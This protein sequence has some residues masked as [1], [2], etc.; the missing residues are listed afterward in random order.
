MPWID[1]AWCVLALA[2][3][4]AVLF[5][6]NLALYNKP[7]A[8]STP[9][10]VSVLIPARNEER[11][12][13]TSVRAALASRNTELE[14]LVLDDNSEDATAE[15]VRC[16][17]S[18]DKRLHLFAAPPLPPGWCGKQFACSVL[19]D[20]AS[21][22][23]LCFIDAD[24]QL[25]PTG[26]ADMVGALRLR[27]SALISGFPQ[28]ITHTALEQLLLPLMH[29]L[30]LGF[31]PLSGM[32]KLVHPSFGAGCGQ[33]FVADREAY[34]KAGGHSAIRNSRHDG[35]TLPKAFRRAGFMTDLCDATSVASCRM[36]RNAH[37]VFYGLLKNATEGLA[38]PSRIVPFSVLLFAGQVLPI[39]LFLFAWTDTSS[40]SFQSVTTLAVIASYL[41]RLI[42][43]VRFKQPFFAALFHPTA[44]LLLLGIQWY[45]LL[46]S[47]FKLPAV[48]KGRSY[49]TT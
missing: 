31:L 37:E 21:S 20:L 4:P 13:E 41:P 39:A 32:R 17:A 22:P 11:S 2:A 19:A 15:I 45:A 18:A 25:T 44:I 47:L 14:V 34:R 36:Y 23:V 5:L 24:V 10:A 7:R 30:L 38:A 12:I 46:R 35:I 40:R 1:L 3:L 42:A 6:W 29:F 26:L 9:E 43:A 49:S 8:S 33:I 28:Q 27:K 16:I 48:W